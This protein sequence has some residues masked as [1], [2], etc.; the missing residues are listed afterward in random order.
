M[1][2]L[3]EIF[4]K[5]KTPPPPLLKEEVDYTFV[6]VQLDEWINAVKL[7]GGPFP[8]VVYY[9]GGVKLIPQDDG[10][11]RL[12]YQY[13]IWDSAGYTKK[14]LVESS[15]FTNRI[16]DVLVAIIADEQGKGEYATPRKHDT[17]ESDV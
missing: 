17:E 3:M 16:G 7:V 9:Y 4:W 5:K 15:V 8:N 13:T 11:N 14:E 2:L 1:K 12:A 10:T 6:E